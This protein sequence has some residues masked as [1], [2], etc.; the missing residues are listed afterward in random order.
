MK[1][2]AVLALVFLVGVASF[3]WAIDAQNQPPAI[4]SHNLLGLYTTTTL[5]HTQFTLGMVGNYLAGPV[6]FE[7]KRSGDEFDAVDTL[8]AGH[9]YGVVGLFKRVDLMAAASYVQVS[10]KD[11]DQINVPGLSETSQTAGGSLGDARLG[12]K[13]NILP[14]KP[15][16]VGLGLNVMASLPTGDA[17][18]YA[19]ND[20]MTMSGA[21]LLDKQFGRVNLALNAGYK[22]LG[23]PSGLEP[24]G[25]LFGGAGA[26]VILAKW[27]GLTG[28]VVGRTLD[29]G[30]DEID[31]ATPLEG[32]IGIRFYTQMGLQFLVAGGAGFTDGIGSPL[33]RGMAGIS[34]TYPAL[35]YGNLPAKKAAY[36]APV[37]SPDA[38]N[39]RDGLTNVYEQKESKTDPANPDTDGDGLT[40]GEEVNKYHTDPLKADTDGD[41]LSDGQEVR[42][43]STNPSNPDTDGDGLTDGQEVNEL[44]TNP[45]DA[46]TDH[47]GLADNKDACPLEP[48]TKNGFMDDDGCPEVVLARK[49]S[50]VVMFENQIVLP[51]PLTFGGESSSALSKADRALLGD[52]INILNEFPKVNVQIEGHIAAG[53]AN[54]AT[55]SEAR[56]QEVRNYLI[57]KGIAAVRLTAIGLGD[58]VPIA[59][60]DTPENRARNTRIDFVIV[61]R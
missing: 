52:V 11:L 45:L 31:P 60:N 24:Q 8:I 58:Q 34:Y 2:S 42:V 6:R 19:G 57:R 30:I 7:M 5:D 17:D 32:L 14:N 33:Y 28:E 13:F 43:Y 37:E 1:R 41:G 26:D 12:A 29:Y 15:G 10:G 4:G 56:A 46:D 47:D 59:P 21:L 53:Q 36:V 49:A 44:R 20:A 25:Q 38:D 3:A 35:V 51:T 16:W 40:D 61:G 48:E 27:V 18:L 22:Y 50:G 54:A 23:D 55:L 39:D 9:F